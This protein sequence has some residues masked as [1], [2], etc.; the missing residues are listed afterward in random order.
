MAS[1]P[2]YGGKEVVR[3]FEKAGWQLARKGGSHM[4]LVHLFVDLF[5]CWIAGE[6]Q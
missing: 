4:I 2:A 5:F 6:L 3:I 1:L